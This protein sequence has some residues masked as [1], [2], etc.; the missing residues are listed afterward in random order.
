M[1]LLLCARHCSRVGASAE[2]PQILLRQR[3]RRPELQLPGARRLMAG[4]REGV[5]LTEDWGS[6]PGLPAGRW[7]SLDHSLFQFLPSLP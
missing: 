6:G 1:W 7:P 2:E 3:R 4:N 5:P